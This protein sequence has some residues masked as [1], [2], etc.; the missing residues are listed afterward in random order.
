M[1]QLDE[2]QVNES[3]KDKVNHFYTVM[4]KS[5]QIYT[6]WTMD[7]LIIELFILLRK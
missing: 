2:S 5:N 1:G 4:E 3:T 6:F 7:A